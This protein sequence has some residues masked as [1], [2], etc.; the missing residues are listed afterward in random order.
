MALFYRKEKEEKQKKLNRQTR[1]LVG[2]LEHRREW[3][4][5]S[6]NIP[7]RIF[8]DRCDDGG[9][10]FFETPPLWSKGGITKQV[11]STAMQQ[12][13]LKPKLS[14]R[15]N[16]FGFHNLPVDAKK[17]KFHNFID[18]SFLLTIILFFR[19]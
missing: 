9:G 6:K 15:N 17:V 11:T 1:S 13:L 16:S 3:K 2:S 5:N 7:R 4:G 10:A 12:S 8:E 19:Q 18:C 14:R